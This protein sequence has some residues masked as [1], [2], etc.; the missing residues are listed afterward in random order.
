VARYSRNSKLLQIVEAQSEVESMG[1][2][3]R[4]GLDVS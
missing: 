3:T 2:P 1:S 4:L